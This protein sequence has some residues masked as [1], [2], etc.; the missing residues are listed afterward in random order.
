MATIFSIVSDSLSLSAHQHSNASCSPSPSV[1]DSD[2]GSDHTRSSS[3][4]SVRLQ[5]DDVPVPRTCVQVTKDSLSPELLRRLYEAHAHNGILGLRLTPS[6]SDKD[7][8][9]SPGHLD[10]TKYLYC[11]G[12]QIQFSP[13]YEVSFIC[14]PSTQPLTMDFCLADRSR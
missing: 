5:D 1:S 8:S 11:E 2:A 7:A 14:V 13:H 12:D 10:E 3:P 9:W 6:L 4:A